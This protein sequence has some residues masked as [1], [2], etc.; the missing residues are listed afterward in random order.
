LKEVLGGQLSDVDE[1]VWTEIVREVDING[2]G[3]IS[4]EEFTTMMLRYAEQ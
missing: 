2:D 3:V 1:N 4:K